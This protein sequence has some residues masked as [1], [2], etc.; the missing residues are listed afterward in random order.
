MTSRGTLYLIPTPLN[1]NEA[2]HPANLS[3]LRFACENIENSLLLIEELKPARQRWIKWGLS[4]DFIDKFQVYNEHN[5]KNDI[6]NIIIDL[7]NGKNGYLFSDGGLPSFCDPG[8]LLVKACHS[9]KIK[10]TCGVFCNSPLQALIMSGFDSKNFYFAGFLPIKIKEEREVAIDNLSKM[11]CPIIL[12]DTPYRLK[13]LLTEL[14]NHKIFS[15]KEAF[16][17]MDLSMQ[18]EEYSIGKISKLSKSDWGKRE[19]I[20]IINS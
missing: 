5:Q 7:K 16:L 6:K 11:K 20:L 18:T 19:F 15:Q 13:R 17:A 3:L 4:R 14:T 2:L 8:Q 10:V 1:E 9:E 12:M